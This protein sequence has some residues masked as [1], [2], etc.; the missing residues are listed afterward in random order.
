MK[1]STTDMVIKTLLS[2]PIWFPIGYFLCWFEILIRLM[3]LLFFPQVVIKVS[4]WINDCGW[5]FIGSIIRYI[6]E[7]QA[8]GN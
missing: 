3:A 4:L 7:D 6:Q 2:F 8:N 5:A 1:S